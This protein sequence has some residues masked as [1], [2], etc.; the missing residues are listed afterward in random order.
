MKKKPARRV[1]RKPVKAFTPPGS[2]KAVVADAVSAMPAC[3][4]DE[5]YEGSPRASDVL[6]PLAFEAVDLLLR[7]RD[8]LTWKKMHGLQALEDYNA[9]H[10]Q[11]G[12]LMFLRGV[13][14]ARRHSRLLA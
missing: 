7:Q 11:H 3:S 12:D 14:Y 4:L 5:L 6:M 13:E 2:E 9:I 10:I 8:R 1:T